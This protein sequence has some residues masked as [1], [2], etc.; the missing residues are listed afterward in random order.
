MQLRQLV[1]SVAMMLS[2]ASAKKNWLDEVIRHTTLDADTLEDIADILDDASDISR[3][4]AQ[5]SGVFFDYMDHM[6]GNGLPV[7]NITC[8]KR[9]CTEQIKSCLGDGT[10]M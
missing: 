10:C 6:F 8:L 2:L 5:Q 4:A 7:R 3:D 9:H 1:L